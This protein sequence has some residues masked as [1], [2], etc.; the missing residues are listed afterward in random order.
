MQITDF[1]NIHK[2]ER[3]Y[4]LGNGPGLADIDLGKLEYPT[5]GTNRIYLA[6]YTP[7]YFACCDPLVLEQFRDEIA[8]VDAPRFIPEEYALDGDVS[9]STD[10]HLPSFSNPEHGL[11]LLYTSPSPR[12]RS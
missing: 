5:F 2:G 6:D 8:E 1:K 12:D 9:I 7:D 4:I 10:N 11:C 3:C